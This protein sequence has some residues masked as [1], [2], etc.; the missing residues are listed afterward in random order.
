[1]VWTE[2]GHGSGFSFHGN[3]AKGASSLVTRRAPTIP[4]WSLPTAPVT[5]TGLCFMTS[6]ARVLQ[7]DEAK[8]RRFFSGNRWIPT[9]ISTPTKINNET[10]SFLIGKI[11]GLV[12]LAD[13]GCHVQ[14]LHKPNGVIEQII[15]WSTQERWGH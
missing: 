1:M 14:T 13:A 8:Q 3:N 5:Q 15:P 9:T 11:H 6:T 12:V 10:S 4:L 7:F 2:A